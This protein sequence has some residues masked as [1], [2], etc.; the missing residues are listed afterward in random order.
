MWFH[1]NQ[2][3]L[4][5]H[6]YLLGDDTSPDEFVCEEVVAAGEVLDPR[7]DKPGN[8]LPLLTMPVLA[9]L[10]VFVFP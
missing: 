7:I 1:K 4:P 9:S 5:V 3:S 8:G 10:D 6:R 2:S